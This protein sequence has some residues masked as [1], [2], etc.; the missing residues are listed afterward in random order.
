MNYATIIVMLLSLLL[1][2]CSKGP[3]LYV[4]NW[5][6]YI[7]PELI[8]EFE[9]EYGCKVK[10]STYDSN[11]NM[12]TKIK[13]SRESFDLV[14]PSGDH[15]S[16]MIENGLAE[17][18]DKAKLTNIAN[19]DTLL[20][21]KANEFDAGNQY[22]LPYFWG[23]TG[24]LYNKQEVPVELVAKQ[25]WN[26]IGD[27]FFSGKRK[28]TM[29]DDAREVV[30]AAMISNGYDV[31][32]TS[33]EAL[34]AALTTL[35]SWD[36]NITQFDSES[37]KN[38]VADGTTWLAQAYNGDALQQ[39]AQNQD[40]GFIFPQE[41]SS[42]WMDNMVIL[43]SSKN[44]ELAYQFINFLLRPEVAQRNADYVQ[45]PTPNAAA[46]ELLE[47]SDKE[48]RLIY[49]DDAYLQKCHMI[50]FLGDEVTKINDLFEKIKM[51]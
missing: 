50:R 9:K 39:M 8:A 29:L 16:I 5:S 12:L 42:L 27:Q 2:S 51:N 33:E 1:G 20:M 4:F 49:P 23:I 40:L 15:V 28:I 46:F 26:V 30:G 18:L 35:Q 43:K 41:G 44:K 47:A 36:G 21:A 32:D 45:Y 17:K 38:E 24:L 48:N 31:N 22:S 10:Y 7:D 6:D 34:A 37:Y 3:V 14:F 11:E 13:S 19:L 25:S